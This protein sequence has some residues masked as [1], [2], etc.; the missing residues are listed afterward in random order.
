MVQWYSHF[1]DEPDKDTGMWIMEPDVYEGGKPITDIIHLDTIVHASHFIAMYGN[2]PVLKGIPFCYALNLFHLYYVN[3][4][5]DH[6]A[7]K[8][9]F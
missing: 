9:A 2:K 7:F 4:Y 6:H 1:G 5:I 3:K 8:I